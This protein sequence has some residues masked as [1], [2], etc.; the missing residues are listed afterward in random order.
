MI[1]RVCELIGEV[2]AE[3]TANVKQLKKSWGSARPDEGTKGNTGKVR[4][5][6]P[7]FFLT[8]SP[9]LTR[10]AFQ[11]GSPR[12]TVADIL[13]GCWGGLGFTRSRLLREG[14]V[15]VLVSVFWR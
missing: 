12:N 1:Q 4:D 10:L 14:T 6:M 7:Q 3:G 13:K 5:L 11:R 2:R 9:P 8:P 15:L